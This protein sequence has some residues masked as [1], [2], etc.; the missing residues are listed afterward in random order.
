MPLCPVC[1]HENP[2]T[3]LFCA[4]CTSP[5]A[6]LPLHEL[7]EADHRECLAALFE[8]LAEISRT[9]T[10]AG[11]AVDRD[12]WRA[13]L[14]AFWLRPETALILYAEA[15]A[16]RPFR[17]AA[18]AGPWLDLG[19]GDGI[20]AAIYSGYRFGVEFD[21]FGALDLAAADIYNHFDLARFS[22]PV[23]RVG[24]RID[25]GLDIKPTAVA[26]ATALGAFKEVMRA[27]A[28]K[29]PLPDRSVGGIFSNMLRDLG[30]PLPAALAEC[31]RVMADDGVLL[32]SAMTPAYAQSLH[33]APA[34]RA[35]QAAGDT[36]R[37]R[38]L[39]KLDRGRSVFCQRQL[40]LDQWRPLLA[41]AGLALR[42]AHPLVGDRA[43]RFWDV[44]LRPFTHAMLSHRQKWLD[45]GLL[46]AI[47]PSLV[48]ALDY[49][50][51]P[52]V[53]TVEQ[54][55]PCMHLLEIGKA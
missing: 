14:D 28:T 53:R 52:L 48:G 22:A 32:L 45:A 19:C 46:G 35:A 17:D 41:K 43:I 47:K 49:M 24:R 9:T 42:R 51:A 29:L 5:V 31:R 6:V 23:E 4:R 50:L 13:Y 10:A 55:T 25:Y 1:S 11:E 34:A 44:G 20:H 27:D 15:L 33:F 39:L 21:A 40:S 54:G 12:L 3:A 7:G 38:H 37:A 36:E 30:E 18:T 2:A 16:V 8:S 26:R